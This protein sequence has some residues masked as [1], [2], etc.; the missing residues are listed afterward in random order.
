MG[1]G[2]VAKERKEIKSVTE[3]G[4]EFE[5]YNFYFLIN[6]NVSKVVEAEKKGEKVRKEKRKCFTAGK[7]TGNCDTRTYDVIR[8]NIEKSSSYKINL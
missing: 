5:I 7:K 8:R 2:C 1:G 3:S 6:R 4:T